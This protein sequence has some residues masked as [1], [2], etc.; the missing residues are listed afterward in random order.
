MNGR[1]ESVLREGYD[2]SFSRLD[3]ATGAHVDPPWCAIYETATYLSSD[4]TLEPFV[5]ASWS[6]EREG[7]RLRITVHPRTFHSGAVCDA[8]AVAAAFRLHSD[9]VESPVNSFFWEA[10][11]GVT[12][13][14]PDVL[15]HLR[16]PRAGLPRLLR[17]WHAAVHNQAER[18]RLGET[19]GLG[20]ADGTGPFRFRAWDPGSWLEVERWSA[21]TGP[22]APS[23]Q[24]RGPALVDRIRWIAIADER[25]RARAL[26]EGE[27]DCAQNISALDVDRIGERPEIEIVTFQQS[28]MIY[29]ALDH[30]TPPFD[31]L[32]V[33]RAISQA[34]D[35]DE[36]VDAELHGY[37]WPG[38]GP[39]PSLDRLAAPVAEPWQ[40]HDTR[41]ASDALDAAGLMADEHGTRAAISVLVLQDA[42][43]ERVARRI[44]RQLRR[45]GIALEIEVVDGF[46]SF[47]GALAR[48]PP[49]FVSKWFWPDP[50]DAIVGFVASWAHAGPN[51]QRASDGAIDDAC[52]AW[53]TASGEAVAAE[54][55][56]NLQL[57]AAE[58]LPL[59]P[60]VSPAAI[61]A[62][63]RRV[64]GWRPNRENLYPLYNDVRLDAAA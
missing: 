7:R 1:S 43:V 47:Y 54:A 3:P 32:A 18:E 38:Y 61:W 35:R 51:W 19:W 2:Y 41:A 4:G 28:A 37:G 48:H 46:D 58:R 62:H 30:E 44:A 29:L 36:L 27:I 16:H 56:L 60:L 21:Y 14:G 23:V 59:V 53:Q 55:A 6:A 25:E 34:I 40:R 20:N 57:L 11:E 31:D 50:V 42:V 10:V 52:H 22:P 5:A 33:R 49:A 64:R 12:V 17:S 45:V 39:I 9:P 63:H 8:R 24:N 15:L 26:E 13:E